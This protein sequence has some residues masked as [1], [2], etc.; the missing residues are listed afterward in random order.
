MET[1]PA[2]GKLKPALRRERPLSRRESGVTLKMFICSAGICLQI[3]AT[4]VSQAG[5]A[6]R[7]RLISK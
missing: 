1:G 3:P 2:G 6:C 5:A 4:S 7:K